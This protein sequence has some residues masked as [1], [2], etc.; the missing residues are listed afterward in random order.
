MTN[1]QFW[2]KLD[3]MAKEADKK[4]DQPDYNVKFMELLKKGYEQDLLILIA[5]SP[6]VNGMAYQG[7]LGDRNARF[8]ICYTSEA[9]AKN[10]FHKGDNGIPMDWNT[11]KVRDM[12]NNMFNKTSGAGLIFNPD[13]KTESVIVLKMLLEMIM[14]G[15]KPKPPMFVDS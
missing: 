8:Y 9:H 1:E 11:M 6:S 14:P 3:Q 15:P 13:S 5:A 2:A 4:R 12:I 7:F 10:D